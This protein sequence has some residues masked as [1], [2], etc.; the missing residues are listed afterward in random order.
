M[1]SPAACSNVQIV[2]WLGL[3]RAEYL[4]VPGLHLTLSQASRLWGLDQTTSVALFD[5]LVD[6]KFLKRTRSGAYVRADTY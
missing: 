1:V 3:I 5:A 6:A 2:D 4:E